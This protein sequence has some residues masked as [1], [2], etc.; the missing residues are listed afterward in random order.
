[1]PVRNTMAALLVA[2]LLFGGAAGA[3]I[4]PVPDHQR[5]SVESTR[6]QALQAAAWVKERLSGFHVTPAR[7]MIGL[8]L[9]GVLVSWNRNKRL[10]HWAVLAGLSW[11]LLLSGVAAIALGWRALG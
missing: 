3:D 2:S 10:R 1:M 7:L 8:G 6:G 5:D 4:D 11:L 9:L